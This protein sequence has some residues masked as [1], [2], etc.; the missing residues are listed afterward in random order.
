[1]V[2]VAALAIPMQ[3]VPVLSLD[4]AVLPRIVRVFRFS[5][6][7]AAVAVPIPVGVIFATRIVV[8]TLV[9]ARGKAARHACC[10]QRC[11]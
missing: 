7:L 10:E 11:C 4:P 3:A 5:I 1:M 6:S 2:T 9:F 8:T